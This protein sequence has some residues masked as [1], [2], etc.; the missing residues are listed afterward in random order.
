MV[1]TQEK[2]KEH[3]VNYQDDTTKAQVSALNWLIRSRLTCPRSRWRLALKSSS[4][5]SRWESSCTDSA[6]NSGKSVVLEMPN[7]CGTRIKSEFASLCARRRPL[8][9]LAT[10]L[11]IS[12]TL[13]LI[14]VFSQWNLWSDPDVRQWKGSLLVC[15]WFQ[16]GDRR[17]SWEARCQ[18]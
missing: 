3:D 4:A 15:A 7:L 6:M 14:D 8:N 2:P 18:I 11:V 16:W 13:F 1:D 5:S 12:K 17:Q 9:P 10:S